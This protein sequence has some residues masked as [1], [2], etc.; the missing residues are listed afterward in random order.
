MVKILLQNNNIVPEAGPGIY[1][2][3]VYLNLLVDSTTVES[4][5]DEV[6]M[7]HISISYYKFSAGSNPLHLNNLTFQKYVILHRCKARFSEKWKKNNFQ[8]Y[9][10]LHRCKANRFIV[11]CDTVLLEVC[12][13]AQVQSS[14]VFTFATR[15]FQKYAILHRCKARHAEIVCRDYFQ[16]Y[17]ILHRC[18]APSFHQHIHR[19]FQKYAFP[20]RC[21]AGHI[22]SRFKDMQYYIDAKRLRYWKGISLH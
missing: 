8:K 1:A 19:L 18:K 17:S 6:G 10:I 3:G 7:E 12:N 15:A 20:C 22:A 14:S 11:L 5:H 21:K 2:Y 16:K 13:F 4:I 9:V